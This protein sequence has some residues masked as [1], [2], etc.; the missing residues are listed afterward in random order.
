[1]KTEPKGEIVIYRTGDGKTSLEAR[2]QKETAFVAKF[3]TV[4]EY[5]PR[6]VCHFP[7]ITKP[8]PRVTHFKK[9]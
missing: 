4:Q 5:Q 6:H 9:E 1:M 7:R 2:V 3:A 8:E